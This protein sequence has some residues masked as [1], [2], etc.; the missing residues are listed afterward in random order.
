MNKLTTFWS[1]SSLGFALIGLLSF[2]SNVIFSADD[3]EDSADVEEVV[4]TGS[5]IKRADNISAPTP[6][7]TLGEDQI[8]LTGSINVYDIL[9]ELPQAGEG[10]SRGNSNFTVGSSGL[11]TVNLRGLG[12]GRT[13][14]L[15]NGR[16]W[17]GGVP[18]TGVVDLNS[19]PTDLIEKLEVITGG[20][21]SVYG[22]D[23]V[24]GVVNIILKDDFEGMSVEVMEGQYNKGD[25]ETSLAS[26]TFGASFG[27]GRG[28]S[29]FNFRVDEQG[30]VMARDRKPYTGRDLFY[31]GYYYGN[32]YGPPYDTFI[33]DPGYSSYVPQGRFF[34][35][36]NNANSA[37][38]KTF[39]CSERGEYSVTKSSTVVD[40]SAAGGSTNCGF[41]RTHFR[42]LEVP[43][44]RYSVFNS[45]NYEFDNGT[46]MF[47]ELSY[48][49]VDSQ[50]EFEPVPFS[51]ED[52]Y[53]GIGTLGYKI[54]NPYMPAEIKAAAVA[55]G[56]TEVPFIRRLLEF[57]TR[58]AENTRETFRAAIGFDGTFA[59]GMD[60]DV[61]YQSGFSDRM[62]YSQNYNSINMANAIDATTDAN[63]NIICANNVARAQGCVPINLFGLMSAS[64]ES[65]NY[66]KAITMRQSKNKQKV[67]AGNVTGDWD[68]L[69]LGMQ[70]AAG[71][72][73]REE[74]GADIPD[75]LAQAGLHG[76]NVTPITLGEYTVNGYYAE[77]LVPLIANQPFAQEVTFETAYR[78][79]HYSTAGAVSAAKM[80]LSWVINDDWRL[81]GVVSE[82]VR[83]PDI[84]DLYSGQAQG[85]TSIADPCAGVGNPAVTIDPVVSA[86]CLSNPD[87]AA[88]AAAGS[89]DVDSG[90]TTPGFNYSQPDTQ[91]ISGFTGGN[92][93]LGEE[94]ADTTTYGIVYTPAAV[95]GLAISV[96]YYEIEIEDVISSV[97]ATRL[98]NECY[99]SANYPNVSQCSAHKRFP[100]TGK[101]RYWYSYGINQSSYETAGIDVAATYSFESLG[102]IPGELNINAIYTQ[103][104]KHEYA[105]TSTS[106][107]FDYVGEVGFNEDIARVNL[108]YTVNDWIVSLQTNYYS[109][110][111]DD[112]G[113][114]AKAYHLNEVDAMVYMDLQV[115]YKL[116]DS[117]DMYFGIDNLTNKQPPYGPTTKNEPTPGAHYTASSYARVWDSE[118]TYLGFKWNL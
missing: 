40:W 70:F 115:R 78:V 97:S 21:S 57:G 20:A 22:S 103:R 118:Y 52:I 107:P 37:G 55:N 95:E 23:A 93:N 79:D 69:D 33:S 25:G 98:I 27:D 1:K 67:F 44:Q 110:A 77:L 101:L 60:W 34:V 88:T 41:N 96:D 61:Y 105:T 64:E 8:E 76:S 3:E 66:V 116:T 80:G 56:A 99:S 4:V 92:P 35:S 11:Q 84:D 38:M 5:R 36:G 47:T 108:L 62:Q 117:I 18:G 59:N 83:A 82:S 9:N 2:G 26:V 106:T 111:L 53:G 28:N 72:E 73:R 104:D 75:S 43:L 102:M 13:L 12:A 90:T 39:D 24:A 112:I 94:S 32:D 15:V 16:R 74:T 63:G 48:T 10:T 71:F 85:Y 65:V 46:H 91:T 6:M 109:E 49:S 45:T 113:Q 89:Y 31:Y 68:F 7:L 29:V 30:G 87:I 17:V 54:T 50:S 42:A 86:N 19:I 81:R 58:G 14:T 114:P 100:G 51:S